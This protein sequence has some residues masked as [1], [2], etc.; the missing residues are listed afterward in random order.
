MLL[1][2]FAELHA[3]DNICSVL[4]G[5]FNQ[6]PEITVTADVFSDKIPGFIGRLIF[7]QQ[8]KVFR[9]MFSKKVTENQFGLVFGIITLGFIESK[10]NLVAKEFTQFLTRTGMK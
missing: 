5:S 6:H 9:W 10:G 2:F 1:L 3:F 8:F 4:L 7:M